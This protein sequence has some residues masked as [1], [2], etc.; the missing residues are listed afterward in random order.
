MAIHFSAVAIYAFPRP[1]AGCNRH[2]PE[3]NHFHVTNSIL[4]PLATLETG[5]QR[6]FA[7]NLAVCIG[8]DEAIGKQRGDDLRFAIFLSRR[9]FVF[10]V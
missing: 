6:V 2:V 1:S 4:F 10:Q 5:E 8:V 7:R 9:P 3:D